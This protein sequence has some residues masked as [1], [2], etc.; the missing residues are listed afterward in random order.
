MTS[1]GPMTDCACGLT[2]GYTLTADDGAWKAT[3]CECVVRCF[4]CGGS[5]WVTRDL[6]GVPFEI[7]CGVCTF[8]RGIAARITAAGI[9]GR[10]VLGP[11][12]PW[13]KEQRAV[14]R[15]LKSAVIGQKKGAVLA[16]PAGVGKT[17]VAVWALWTLLTDHGARVRYR[18]QRQVFQGLKLAMDG[19]EGG[20]AAVILDLTSAP[21]LLWDE[22]DEPSSEWQ[23]SIL[24]EVFDLRY[25]AGKQTIVTT[26]LSEDRI[27]DV[28]GY[29]GP[30]MLSRLSEWCPIVGMGGPDL[31]QH[32]GGE[33]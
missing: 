11:I 15:W 19:Q 3:P 10:Y 27:G 12:E 29:A 28:W 16:G 13:S 6:E 23:R 21:V 22:L 32:K 9:A 20:T 17:Q 5:G 14:M 33:R 2:T 18:H 31:R 24:A 7:R 1:Q 4:N 30:R 26:N 8:K 25:Q